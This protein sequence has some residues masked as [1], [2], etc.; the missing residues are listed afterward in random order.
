M[1]AT[2][3]WQIPYTMLNQLDKANDYGRQTGFTCHQW[4]RCQIFDEFTPAISNE[5]NAKSDKLQQESLFPFP[6]SFYRLTIDKEISK[7]F[8][9]YILCKM[10]FTVHPCVLVYAGR[11]NMSQ[12][13]QE[14]KASNRIHKDYKSPSKLA[15]KKISFDL[16][17]L[18]LTH[19]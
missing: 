18:L 8:Y 7:D 15:E 12:V 19:I 13:E 10:D 5:S 2:A 14:H 4:S 1:I 11:S 6:S 17:T 9:L 16:S 3:W